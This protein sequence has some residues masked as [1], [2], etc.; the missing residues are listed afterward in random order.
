MK[1]GSCCFFIFRII[2]EVS[3]L[4]LKQGKH[5]EKSALVCFY[6]SVYDCKLS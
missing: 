2:Y 3:L 5:A 4:P 6:G 1:K